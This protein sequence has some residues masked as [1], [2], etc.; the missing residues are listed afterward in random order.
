MSGNLSFT[1][2]VAVVT[3][4]GSGIGQALAEECVRRGCHVVLVD[5]DKDAVEAVEREL[6][7]ETSKAQ[8]VVS[9]VVD[10]T[11]V[12]SIEALHA[13]VIKTFGQVHFVFNNAG[14]AGPS[15][16]FCSTKDWDWILGLNLH[17]VVHGVRLF[18]ATMAAQDKT[19]RCHIIN[20]ASIYGL[21]RGKGPY[22]VT[23][24]AVVAISE[25]AQIEL[26][27]IARAESGDPKD[28]SVK[29]HVVVSSLCPSYIS[30]NIANNKDSGLYG[31]RGKRQ[32]EN[33][34]L[35]SKLS[36]KF[37]ETQSPVRVVVDKT[38]AGIEQGLHYIHTHPEV[39]SAVLNSRVK[40]ILGDGIIGQDSAEK[41]FHAERERITTGIMEDEAA[42]AKL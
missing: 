4:A 19:T 26:D 40:N 36:Q 41:E 31:D 23:K 37:M 25:G 29:S 13:Y 11:D 42:M 7:M 14:A 17:S 34:A 33:A 35:A 28:T 15:S 22:G 6:A 27:E 30:T 20:T 12:E 5:F 3:G 1:H 10:V 16:M 18:G 24:Q 38:F 9:R 8:S 39:S 21:A 32:D 2:K